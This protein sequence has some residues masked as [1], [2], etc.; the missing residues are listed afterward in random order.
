VTVVDDVARLTSVL[1][2]QY[3]GGTAERLRQTAG[4]S[5]SQI[6][7]LCGATADM[8]YAWERGT[9]SPSTQQALAWLTAL[10]QAAPN[11]LT[12]AAKSQE[13]ERERQEAERERAAATEAKIAW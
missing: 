10:H 11:P 1:V 5:A 6:G 12:L 8:V 3:Q 2:A 9:L 13:A 7:K 4:V